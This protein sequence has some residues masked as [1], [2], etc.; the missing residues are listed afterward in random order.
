MLDKDLLVKNSEPVAHIYTTRLSKETT[1]KQLIRNLIDRGFYG[2]LE[3]LRQ[4]LEK[5]KP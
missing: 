3:D 5:M 2:R 1:Q 4:L